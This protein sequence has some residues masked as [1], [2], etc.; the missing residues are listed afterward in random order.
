MV[1]GCCVYLQ[2]MVDIVVQFYDVLQPLLPRIIDLLLGFVRRTH[3]SLAS[4]GVAA[5]VR[6]INNA[7]RS[8]HSH[9]FEICW[10]LF[11]HC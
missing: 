3:K 8:C 9:Y 10:C 6:L 1:E 4:V 5:F 11:H 7:G 2:N